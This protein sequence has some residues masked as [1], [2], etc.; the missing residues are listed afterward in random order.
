[1][2][3]ETFNDVYSKIGADVVQYIG[4]KFVFR[5]D[6]KRDNSKLEKLS[7]NVVVWFLLFIFLD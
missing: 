1:M 2:Q 5:I 6:A 3:V 4:D 7:A